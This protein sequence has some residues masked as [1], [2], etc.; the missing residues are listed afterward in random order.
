M[1][2]AEVISQI[3]ATRVI[4]ILRGD[5][6]D[7]GLDI[8]FALAEAGI[9]ALEVSIVSPEYGTVIRSL[10]DALGSRLAIG[11]GTV[12][13]D[14]ACREVADCGA[15]FVVS[16][17]CETTVIET[18]RRLGMASFPGALTPTEIV[19]ADRSGADAIKIFPADLVGP[20]GLALLNGPFPNIRFIPTGGITLENCSMYSAAGAWAVG[21]GS[22][23]V[24]TSD[25]RNP[26][27]SALMERARGFLAPGA[28]ASLNA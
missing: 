14:E 27:I 9:R 22:E 18:T 11:A 1:T 5:L 3:E 21:V 24:H 4:S 13:T 6:R 10:A 28:R 25:C 12:L 15:S 8:A 2:H 26:D 16:P 23:L 7:T 19:V 17:N 20:R